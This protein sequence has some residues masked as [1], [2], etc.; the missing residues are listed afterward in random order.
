VA[1]QIKTKVL[2]AGVD[3]VILS[4]ATLNGYQPG[5]ITAVA[6]KLRPLL[7]V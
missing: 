4:A 5:G 1:D 2:D 6:E 3:G 7:G